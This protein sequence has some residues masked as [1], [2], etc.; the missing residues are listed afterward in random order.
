MKVLVRDGI[1]VSLTR[2]QFDAPVL[3]L[4][5]QRIGE[6]GIIR[7]LEPTAMTECADVRT[8]PTATRSRS[9]IAAQHLGSL[10][11]QHLRATLQSLLADELRRHA[12]LHAG[13]TPVAMLKPGSGKN[14]REF[15]QLD[16]PSAWKGTLVSDGFSGYH[17]CFE[18]G[19]A[20]AQCMA[21]A[22]R[23]F[24]ELWTNHRSEVGRQALGRSNRLFAGSLRAGKRPAAIMSL[25][26]SARINRHEPYTYLKDV[27]ERLA[28]HPASRIDELL[29]HR[30]K[31]AS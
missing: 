18:K 30:W 21:H 22:R 12:V 25:L 17:G 11:P 7:I 20:S 5:W 6:A 27:L 2:P 14:V 31:P 19:V 29:P 16:T 26:H 13:E 8:A 9:A 24:H 4:P 1:G 3:G 15:L 23:K 10:D 28:T